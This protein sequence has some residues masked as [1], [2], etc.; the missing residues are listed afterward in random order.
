MNKPDEKGPVTE[1]PKRFL[2][3]DSLHKAVGG[4]RDSVRVAAEIGTKLVDAV[5]R[6]AAALEHHSGQTSGSGFFGWS[7]ERCTCGSIYICYVKTDDGPRS[8]CAACGEALEGD[9]DAK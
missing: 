4:A 9:D 1:L 7:S 2:T 3:A 5:N 6:V 8:R